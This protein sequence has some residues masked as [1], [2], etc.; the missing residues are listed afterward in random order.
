MFPSR[1]MSSILRCRV[2]YNCNIPACW[3]WRPGLLL[4]STA[5]ELLPAFLSHVSITPRLVVNTDNAYS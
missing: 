2:R 3:Y 1:H 4:S 5:L